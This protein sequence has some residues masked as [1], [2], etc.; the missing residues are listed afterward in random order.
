MNIEDLKTSITES[1]YTGQ[2]LNINLKCQDKKQLKENVQLL[3]DILQDVKIKNKNDFRY[4]F[5]YLHNYWNQDNFNCIW[6]LT[7]VDTLSSL[8]LI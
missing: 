2:K 7:H 8:S 6:R 1:Y 5:L 4:S 3:F